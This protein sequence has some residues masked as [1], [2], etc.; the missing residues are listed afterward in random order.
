MIAAELEASVWASIH[1]WTALKG[2]GVEECG[3]VELVGRAKRRERGELR[4]SVTPISESGMSEEGRA[5]SPE[6]AARAALSFTPYPYLVR[7]L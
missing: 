2:S 1:V 5:P 4:R 3:L 6:G 7:R